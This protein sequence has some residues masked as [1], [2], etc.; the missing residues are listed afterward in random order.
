M[1]QVPGDEERALRYS[2]D[3]ESPSREPV[4]T[5]SKVQTI[6]RLSLIIASE[7]DCDPGLVISERKLCPSTNLLF[8][9]AGAMAL[10]HCIRHIRSAGHPDTSPEARVMFWIALILSAMQTF[11][12]IARFIG[13]CRWNGMRFCGGTILLY[14]ISLFL[15]GPITYDWSIY[16]AAMAMIYLYVCSHGSKIEEMA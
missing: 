14:G 6:F 5:P 16:L 13:I 9:F 2:Q 11:Y 7:C 8:I 12:F 4:K 3:D 15:L 10:V 1:I